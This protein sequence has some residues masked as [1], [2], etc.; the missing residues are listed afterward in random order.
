MSGA[1]DQDAGI[2]KQLYAHDSDCREQ[3]TTASVPRA[4]ASHRPRH[5]PTQHELWQEKQKELCRSVR[6]RPSQE[7][8]NTG[9]RERERE[10]VSRMSI[11]ILL[12]VS[13]P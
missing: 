5:Q 7:E 11:K 13:H 10:C 2:A 6:Y 8:E 12:V 1:R 4:A 3:S 9:E